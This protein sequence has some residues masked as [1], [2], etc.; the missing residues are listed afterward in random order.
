MVRAGT[1][2]RVQLRAPLCSEEWR[3]KNG[4]VVKF[5]G[6]PGEK[7]QATWPLAFLT[8]PMCEDGNHDDCPGH[9][10]LHGARR[11]EFHSSPPVTRT[12]CPSCGTP[13]TYRHADR[14]GEIAVT[15]CSLD[16]PAVVPPT[17]H[18]WMSHSPHW[19]RFGDDLPMY[20]RSST[21]G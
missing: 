17:Y 8:F 19:L 4:S 12:F 7:L 1:G 20:D 15:T 21:E 2:G 6:E 11:G 14:P 16:D 5:T 18:S 13:V 9:I 10:H 3:F